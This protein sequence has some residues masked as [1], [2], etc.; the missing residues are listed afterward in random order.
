MQKH[1]P[2]RSR[3]RGHVA[4][5]TV[6]VVLVSA[7]GAPCMVPSEQ[8]PGFT[9]ADRTGPAANRVLMLPLAESAH[10][11]LPGT[12]LR[13]GFGDAERTA[14]A[15]LCVRESTPD[16]C[17][18]LVAQ[19]GSI[20]RIAEV[21]TFFIDRT[22]TTLGAYSQC[23]RAGP[24]PRIPDPGVELT[25]MQR[26]PA[27]FVDRDAARAYCQF[28][29]GRLP[30]QQEFER[31]ARG[32]DSRV[33]PWGNL[34]NA[35][36]SNHGRFGGDPTDAVDGF[37]DRSPVGSFRAG[38]TREGIVDLAGN[39]AEWVEPVPAEDPETATSRT[40]SAGLLCGGSYK[41][42][43]VGLSGAACLRAEAKSRRSDVGFR[44]AYDDAVAA[45][46]LE[47]NG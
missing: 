15:T 9:D 17:L 32:A 6:C 42:G 44:C 46:A 4:F 35:K 2:T 31:A 36:V 41:S 40:P 22:E 27:T 3:S 8:G 24:C 30:T 13:V 34:Y 29:R 33:F 20:P 45:A 11:R 18:S 5:A 25:E 16:E 21:P 47:T 14:L 10:I 12:R 23:V 38:A 1:A 37:V 26:L 28:R 19:L 39:V 43:S 7:H